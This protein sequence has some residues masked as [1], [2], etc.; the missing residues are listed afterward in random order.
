MT[1]L[2]QGIDTSNILVRNILGLAS[3]LL[4]QRK[5]TRRTTLLSRRNGRGAGPRSRSSGHSLGLRSIGNLYQR[6]KEWIRR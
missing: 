4:E 2:S 3:L 6:R 5:C 1:P